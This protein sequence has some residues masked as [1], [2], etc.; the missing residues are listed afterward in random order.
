LPAAALLH[1]FRNVGLVEAE[2]SW[3]RLLPSHRVFG[4][5]AGLERRLA[6]WP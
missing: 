2:V 5:H 4:K 3:Y 6:T 1:W